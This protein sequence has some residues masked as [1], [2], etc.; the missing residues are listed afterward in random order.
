MEDKS[1]FWAFSR[2]FQNNIHE[3][4]LNRLPISLENGLAG[5]CLYSL[6]LNDFSNRVMF[7]IKDV[8][9][10]IQNKI[11]EYPK[12]RLGIFDGLTGIALTMAL[13]IR[14]GVFEADENDVLDDID[15]IVFNQITSE[16][17]DLDT[18]LISQLLMYFNS[19]LKYIKSPESQMIFTDLIYFLIEKL[20]ESIDSSIINEPEFFTLKNKM[21][22]MILA[23]AQVKKVHVFNYRISLLE[24]EL[25]HIICS[26]I[27]YLNTNRFLYLYVLS[28]LYEQSLDGKTDAFLLNIRNSISIEEMVN[29]ELRNKDVSLMEGKIGLCF[30]MRQMR[31]FWSNKQLRDFQLICLNTVYDS[32]VWKDKSGINS[33]YHQASLFNGFLGIDLFLKLYGYD[34]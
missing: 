27:P 19:R 14:L 11:Y 13:G 9:G 12:S 26:H 1:C 3:L 33:L 17:Y 24:R 30:I 5:I 25:K 4:D 31:Q 8:I 10:I 6:L 2:Y 34:S 20:N 21:A 22:T 15:S 7:N 18:Y 29:N 28:K 16:S 23:I 32:S